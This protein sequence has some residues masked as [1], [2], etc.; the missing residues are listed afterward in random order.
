[1]AFFVFPVS[2]VDLIKIADIE[3]TMPAKSTFIEPK[4]LAG[5]I[6]HEIA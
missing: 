2:V 1:M 5:L 4:F 3:E 6:T